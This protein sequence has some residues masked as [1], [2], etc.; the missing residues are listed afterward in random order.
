MVVDDVPKTAFKTHLGHYEFLVM[1][2]GLTNAPST[3]QCLMNHIFQQHLRKFVLVFFDDILIYSR[4]LQDHV[5]HLKSVF[6]LM[7]HHQ[8]LAKQSKC[9]FGVS[10]VEYLG[11]FI[12]YEGVSTDQRKIQAVQSWP[13]PSTL[14][15]LRVFFRSGR[16][17][18]KVYSGIWNH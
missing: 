14:K 10:K 5:N 2:F 3:F 13:V 9:V 11:H 18:Q 16:L 7:I 4:S 17:L 8:L 12:S 6:D 15:Q 1:P